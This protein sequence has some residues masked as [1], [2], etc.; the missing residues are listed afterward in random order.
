MPKHLNL[1]GLL[2]NP[3][4]VIAGSPERIR[5]DEAISNQLILLKARLPRFTRNDK[6]TFLTGFEL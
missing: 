3:S 6:K 4:H 5:D 2:K 1:D